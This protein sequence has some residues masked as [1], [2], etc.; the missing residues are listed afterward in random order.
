MRAPVGGAGHEVRLDG[1]L[2]RRE[3][4]HD[5]EHLPRRLD[6]ER[7]R[8]RHVAHPAGAEPGRHA[9]HGEEQLLHV[10]AAGGWFLL[11]VAAAAVHQL[12]LDV[13]AVFAATAVGRVAGLRRAAV[14]GWLRHEQIVEHLEQVRV[15]ADVDRGELVQHLERAEL[16][17]EPGDHP[18][19][20][21]AGLAGRRALRLEDPAEEEE[22]DLVLQ[23]EHVAEDEAVRRLPPGVVDE[24]L[25]PRRHPPPQGLAVAAAGGGD[26]ALVG[27]GDRVDLQE[28][29]QERAVDEHHPRERLAA[30][31]E[32]PMVVS[33]DPA[34][35]PLELVDE[36]VEPGPAPEPLL[37]APCRRE[38]VAL[39]LVQLGA[40]VVVGPQRDELGRVGLRLV[41][42]QRLGHVEHGHLDAVVVVVVAP[43]AALLQR[44]PDL[45][46][47]P[48]LVEHQRRRPVTAGVV[49][50]GG[51]HCQCFALLLHV[52]AVRTYRRCG[53]ITISRSLTDDN[54]AHL[55]EKLA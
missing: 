14:V 53:P 17:H 24:V 23:H 7:D 48:D 18:R 11:F 49:Q 55:R 45:D 40:P 30:E 46:H 47:P 21:L 25:H 33:A 27:R 19:E 1:L 9:G 15:L 50:I 6:G 31:V 38:L 29:E 26:V 32:V 10:L 12:L 13:V 39:H 37:G 28:L 5:G 54:K 42:L 36:A 43:G 2:H 35:E 34:L 20:Q 51:R 3:P 22:R 4:R 52:L 41:H 16:L 44:L 8:P